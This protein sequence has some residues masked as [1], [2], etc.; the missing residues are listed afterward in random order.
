V[1]AALFVGVV[2][3]PGAIYMFLVTGM[4]I[5]GSAE[6]VAIILFIEIAKRSFVRLRTQE[7]I[8]LYW[9]V[10]GLIATEFVLGAGGSLFG[11]PFSALIWFQYF[12]QSPQ[13]KGLAEHI[14]RWVVPSLGSEAILN[15][16]F[17]HG[18][19]LKP[20][21]VLIPTVLL[22]KVNSVTLGYALFRL[23]NDF[24]RLQF[25]LAVV[26][27]A[28]ATALAETSAKQEGWRWRVFST[29]TFI[30]VIWGLLYVVVP[31]LSGIF[32]TGTV[33]ILPIPFID[34]TVELKSIIP[35]AVIGIGTDLSHVFAGFYLPFWVVVGTFSCSMLM[36]FVAN[37]ILYHIR[38]LHTWSPGMAMFP[39]LIANHLD[40]YLSFG[41]GATLVVAFTGM[42][43]AM[44][45]LIGQR[46]KQQTGRPGEIEGMT[47]PEGRGD[48]NIRELLQTCCDDDD[49]YVSLQLHLL[50][51]R[52]EVSSYPVG[53]LPLR[54]ASLAV[55]CNVAGPLGE[56]DTA[57][58]QK[59]DHRVRPSQ[60]YSDR[61][62]FQWS[63]LRDTLC[64]E[65]ADFALLWVYRRNQRR[66]LA[67]F[68]DSAICGGDARTVLFCETIWPG[69]MA[70]LR[71]DPL[72]GIRVRDGVGRDD[73]DC[74]CAHLKVDLAAGVL[75]TVASFRF[76]V[77]HLKT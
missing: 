15:R 55:P 68:H 74:G 42:A 10:G 28:G 43:F 62:G 25:P 46:R 12:I 24:E 57:R 39:T 3:L 27:A 18:D 13:A 54:P 60:V 71:S 58:G 69:T 66:C 11:G 63:T 37:P 70:D 73:L 49:H 22:M 34:L 16:T 44:K 51:I 61:D 77:E 4:S 21:A 8:I 23:T 75:K 41:I 38:V 1:A 31:T 53:S 30:G 19:W 5:A 56:I 48:I 35:A 65:G 72:G 76:Q 9:V 64:T 2:L 7:I 67:S 17:F 40:F 47:P 52:L 6:W 29:G 36:N 14:P 33:Q 59:P 32:L 26:G 20:I 45:I 50:V